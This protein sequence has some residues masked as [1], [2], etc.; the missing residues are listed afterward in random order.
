M[1]HF[2][3]LAAAQSSGFGGKAESLTTQLF[4]GKDTA[5]QILTMNTLMMVFIQKVR[6]DQWKS[7]SECDSACKQT[8]S[9]KRISKHDH[10]G[11]VKNPK[12]GKKE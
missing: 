3:G 10:E 2:T 7:C 9:S 5:G 1:G 12:S 11:A 6:S 4:F 8:D